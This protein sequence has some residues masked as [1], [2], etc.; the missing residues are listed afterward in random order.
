MCEKITGKYI[1]MLKSFK[2]KISK[3]IISL[4]ENNM[5]PENETDDFL[6]EFC[7]NEKSYE[8]FVINKQ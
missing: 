6:V 5:I 4:Y 8:Q 7:K 3:R 2:E 1:D